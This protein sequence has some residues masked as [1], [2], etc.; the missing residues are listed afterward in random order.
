MLSSQPQPLTHLLQ[1]LPNWL[2]LGIIL[3]GLGLVSMLIGIAAARQ[4]TLGLLVL[5]GGP[6]AIAGALLANRYFATL[7][8]LLPLTALAMRPLALPVGNGS[9][10]PISMILSLGL[11]GLWLAAMLT[12]RR[13]ELLPTPFNRPLLAFMVVCIISLPWGIVWADPV[14]NWW[15]MG[16]FRVTQ[17][18]S[19]LMLLALMGLPFLIARFITR[20]WQ[21]WVYVWSFIGCG[22][23][24]TA[25]QFFGI[26]QNLFSDQGLWGLWFVLPL[27]GLVVA[28]PGVARRWRWLGTGLVIWHLYLVV[29][30][31]SL[32]LSGWLPTIIGLLALIFLHSRKA[33][34][35]VMILVVLAAAVGPGRHY[36]EQVTA[37]NIEEGGLGR[38]E[39]W[40]RNL[41][42]VG[43]HWLL[44]MGPAGYAPYNMT[45]FREDARST[46]NNYFDIV[47][48]F[49]VI[50][51]GLWLWFATAVL[52]Y[53][54][55]TVQRARPGLVR[56][57]AIVAT[58]GWVAS[59]AA[60]MLGDWI[61]PFVYNQSITGFRY[62]AYSWIFLGLLIS[63]NRLEPQ[64]PQA[65]AR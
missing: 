15:I 49:G 58:A 32:W 37:D 3:A 24:M 34:A 33:F 18:A 55:R 47:A 19:L 26:E 64:Q 61:L 7:V 21:I 44:G 12:R 53:G 13:W 23:L 35:V 59:L 20:P 4:S 41:S 25:T 63:A 17:T 29:I 50:G 14:L 43:Q 45:Y 6:V 38:L 10:M 30:R 5:V 57:T 42:I 40:E 46:H 52:W 48:Q 54:W 22:V 9:E 11:I 28:H 8:L 65:V 51:L 27:T 36:L 2:R 16:N 31:N 1:R 60:M 56:T 39:I 62:A